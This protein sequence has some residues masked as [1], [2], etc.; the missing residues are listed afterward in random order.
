MT[1]II[2]Q[3]QQLDFTVHNY[4]TP[5]GT[6]CRAN[7][8]DPFGKTACIMCLLCVRVRVGVCGFLKGSFILRVPGKYYS[9]TITS[10]C[11]CAVL[12]GEG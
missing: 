4:G 10:T 5:N 12:K 2:K 9:Y 7:D 6:K 11:T 3:Q 8:W 1:D